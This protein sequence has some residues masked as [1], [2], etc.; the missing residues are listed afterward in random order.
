ML[1]DIHGNEEAFLQV[2]GKINVLN[3]ENMIFLGDLVDYGAK[4]KECTQLLMEQN[5]QS[6]LGNHDA[7][8]IDLISWASFGDRIR[9]SLNWTKGILTGKEKKFLKTMSEQKICLGSKAL[10]ASPIDNFFHY[11]HTVQDALIVFRLSRDLNF[12]VGHTHK[13]IAFSYNQRFQIKQILPLHDFIDSYQQSSFQLKLNPLMRYIINPG[14]VGQPRDN[15]NRASFAVLEHQNDIID[16]V[17][18]YRIPYDIAKTKKQ[19]NEAGLPSD[20]AERL[21]WGR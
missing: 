5:C 11:V 21:Q 15:D 13:A 20:F 3:I 8:V 16:S 1:S 6:V 9:Y 17:T 10:H 14:S 2:L 18:W 12:L 4:P 7:A 19:I